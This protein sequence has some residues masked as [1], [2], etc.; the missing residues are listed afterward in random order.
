MT[1]SPLRGEVWMVDLDPTRGHEQA[2][3][4]PALVVSD[5]T[6]NQGP[7]GLVIVVPVTSRDK[8]VRSH[9]RVEPPEGGLRTISFIKCEDVRSVS[10]ARLT[11]RLGTVSQATLQAVALRLRVL[12]DL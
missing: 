11:K 1:D 8:R 5:D 4:R 7:A 12:M 3:T 9:V 10:I 2:G 6:F